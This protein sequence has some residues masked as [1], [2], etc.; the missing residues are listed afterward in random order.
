MS[1]SLNTSKKRTPKTTNSNQS[2]I[3]EVDD[4]LQKGIDNIY[5]SFNLI[6]KNYKDKI[7]LLENEINNLLQKL[8]TMKKELEMVQRE[9]KY[10]KDNNNKLKN[11]IEK[12]NKIINN[13]KGK[14]TDGDEELN[15]RIKTENNKNTNLR[16][17]YSKNNERFKNNNKLYLYNTYKNTIYNE[18]I[19]KQR[20]KP[21]LLNYDSEKK[22]ELN[23]S[24]DLELNINDINHKKI[25]YRE[26]EGKY[27][28]PNTFHCRYKT[29]HASRE[30]KIKIN[31]FIEKSED[32]QRNSK[33]NNNN[34]NYFPN[35]YIDDQ[36]NNKIQNEED[37]AINNEDLN[38]EELNKNIIYNNDNNNSEL[39]KKNKKNHKFKKLE[40]NICLT[41]ENLFNNTN[42]KEIQKNKN[43]YNTFR[44]KIFS[45][46]IWEK[47]I[48][49]KMSK[50]SEKVNF[51]LNKCKSLLDKESFDKILKIFQDYKEGIITDK[52]IILQ[53]KK[54]IL[55]NKELVDLFN[56]VFSK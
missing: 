2:E 8:E 52:G 50:D 55:N 54:H 51:F 56:K 9:N 25:N 31:D 22:E 6:H 1:S 3:N 5:Y 30:E 16:K 37:S 10:Y 15:Q 24:P 48:E 39:I 7:S 40:Q 21:N 46:N 45:K 26:N 27:K 47:P 35:K 12:L 28:Y 43:N 36:E 20:I 32:I 13:I 11:E 23:S 17:F 14:L 33:K 4:I 42:I 44:G 38:M 19:K 18:N 29:A 49:N 41:Y 34:K 53:M